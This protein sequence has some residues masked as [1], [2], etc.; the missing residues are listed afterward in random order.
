MRATQKAKTHY[1]DTQST[2]SDPQ[3]EALAPHLLGK[4]ANDLAQALKQL[5]VDDALGILDGLRDKISQ[6]SI[7]QEHFARLVGYFAW[8]IDFSSSYL[9]VVENALSRY[10]HSSEASM[11]ILDLARLDMARGLVAF[12]HERYR[13]ARGH[14]D[15]AIPLARRAK[16]MELI[17]VSQY[18]MARCF[19]RETNYASALDCARD[20]LKNEK[21]IRA[22]KRAAVIEL[23]RGYIFSLVAKPEA[24]ERSLSNAMQILLTTND[25]INIGNVLSFQGQRE[26]RSGDYKSAIDKFERAIEE[27]KRSDPSHRNIARSSLNKALALRVLASKLE[28]D[29][30]FKESDDRKD[31]YELRLAGIQQLRMDAYQCLEDANAIYDRNP[32]RHCRGLGKYHYIRASLSVDE[33]KFDIAETEARETYRYGRKIQNNLLMGKARIVQC[34]VEL[35]KNPV[36]AR[37]ALDLARQAIKHAEITQYPRLLSRAYT[38]YGQA[39]LRF[40]FSDPVDASR[41]LGMARAKLSENDQDYVLEEVNDL[42]NEIRSCA[43]AKPIISVV[44]TGGIEGLT[45]EQIVQKAEQSVVRYVHERNDKKINKTAAALK[46]TTRRIRNSLP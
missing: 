27:Y 45:L 10:E 38:W 40:P 46:T 35:E 30:H 13:T 16:D 7:A 14:L 17:A 41:Y 28:T 26:R 25:H 44:T 12:H 29:R 43:D 6:L 22:S 2:A 24:A 21:R 1:E 11:S 33:G 32:K 23:L 18:Y 4:I 37:V 20:A 5:E 19:W 8:A 36:S 3:K 39:L 31:A 42:E 15:R 9:S 34:M